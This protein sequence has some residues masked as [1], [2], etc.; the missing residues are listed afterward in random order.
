VSE[1][2][3][4]TLNLEYNYSWSWY[5]FEPMASG[6]RERKK[7]QTRDRI[8]QAA[9]RQFGE[10]GFEAVTVADV[11]R[12]AEVAPQTVFNYFPTKEDLFY[13]RLEA[14]EDELLAAIRNRD[15]GTSVLDGFA[16]FILQPSGVF[17]LRASDDR[18]ETE[19]QTNTRVITDSPALLARE[20][21]IFDRYTDSLAALIADET[22]AGPDDVVPRA[23]AAALLGVHRALI[24]YVR[25][26]VLAGAS[27][28]Q[29]A[30]G[31]RSEAA[32]AVEQL[33]RGLGDY[34]LRGT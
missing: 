29:I 19:L 9:R 27:S 30:P 16:D 10:R 26:R 17:D 6:L 11:A 25:R 1:N 24:A 18:A 20:R 2:T 28:R 7:E 5:I 33:R 12:E 14:F 34:A 15:P 32:A 21:Q 8:A 23:A 3:I 13:S 22:G 4:A 31:L